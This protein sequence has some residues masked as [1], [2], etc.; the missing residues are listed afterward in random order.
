MSSLEQKVQDKESKGFMKKALKLGYSLGL[1]G[2]TT[3][4]STSFVG[5]TGMWIGG[6]LAAGS[7]LGSAIRKSKSF[8]DNLV[9]SIKTYANINAIITPILKVW[10]W[11][12]PLISNETI[13]GKIARGLFASTAFNAYFEV[14]YKGTQH[15]IDNYLNPKGIVKSIKDNFYNRWKRS[16][17]GFSPAYTLAA[18]GL[19]PIYGIPT[20]AYNALG[21]GLYNSL[22][23]VPVGKKHSTHSPSYAPSL[24]PAH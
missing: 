24:Q 16:G 7:A 20:F 2:A 22:Y 17:T 14:M 4:L 12:I 10:D 6:L 11:T 9:D 1:A 3:A 8:Y 15:L 19:T 18:N 21:L 13:Y 5:T 23:P